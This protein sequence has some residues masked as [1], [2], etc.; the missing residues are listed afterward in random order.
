MNQ[1]IA[2]QE[3]KL[4]MG[5]GGRYLVA[6]RF[7]CCIS[8][9]RK[10][11]WKACETILHD[12]LNLVNMVQRINK[13]KLTLNDKLETVKKNQATDLDPSNEIYEGPT[14]TTGTS[15]IN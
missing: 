4:N 6:R 14:G 13:E 12:Q 5:W 10:E 8:K 1:L 2:G 15:L 9:E 7:F 11:T 3:Y